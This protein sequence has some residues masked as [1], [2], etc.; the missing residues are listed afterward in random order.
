MLRRLSNIWSSG[1]RIRGAIP[2]DRPVFHKTGT[3]HQRICDL[4]IVLLEDDRPLVLAIAVEGI[5]RRTAENIM[6]K[7]AE[8]AYWLA[9]Y[10]RVRTARR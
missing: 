9:N 5:E 3:Q 7:V 4:S 6:F 1:H 2:E 10:A 8:S